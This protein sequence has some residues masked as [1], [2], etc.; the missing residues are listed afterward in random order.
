MK[1]FLWILGFAVGFVVPAA[2]GFVVS[3]SPP[4][5]SSRAGFFGCLATTLLFMTAG[6]A[7]WR[8]FAFLRGLAFGAG[9]WLV[10]LPAIAG[11]C[12]KAG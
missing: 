1:Y 8:R 12:T 7:G 3:I 11:D 4:Y 9:V 2:V 5:A 10:I 6:I